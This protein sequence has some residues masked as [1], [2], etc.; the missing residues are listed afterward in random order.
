MDR[1]THLIVL[2]SPGAG[3]SHG[4]E[5]EARHWFNRPRNGE[6]LIIVSSGDCKTW[7]EIREHLVPPALREN[8]TSEPLWVP[9]QHR[10]NRIIANPVDHQVHE[11]LVEDLK[12][13][14]LRF[15]PDRDWG[16]LRGAERS[17]RRR[18][19]RLLLGT[20]LV[21][22]ILFMT[23]L[24][25]ALYANQRR[26]V[27]ESHALSADAEQTL[28]RDRPAALNLAIRGWQTARTHEA[29]LA[30]AHALP[31]L[32]TKIEGHRGKV[33]R[34]AFSPDGRRIVT[35]SEDETA[36]VW[37]ATNGQLLVT[38]EGHTHPV[39]SAVFSPDGQRIITASDDNTARVY[40]VVTLSEFATLLAK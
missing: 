12:Q 17:Q 31:E 2:A 30:V 25:L 22:L 4:M 21:F 35:A 28:T 5:I 19:V 1:S 3:A 33:Y 18:A 39:K 20:A 16:Q 27:A 9:L 10:R 29:N 24:G 8:L 40:R 37:N 36:R 13:V 14:L 32:L 7:E 15:Y 23:A 38:L 26:L 6:V 34:A 11:E